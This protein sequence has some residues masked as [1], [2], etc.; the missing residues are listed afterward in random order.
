M[1]ICKQNKNDYILKIFNHI[2][3][4]IKRKNNFQSPKGKILIVVESLV[5]LK[6]IEKS[7]CIRL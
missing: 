2:N 5:S 7:I 3:S 4:F 1:Q 6:D